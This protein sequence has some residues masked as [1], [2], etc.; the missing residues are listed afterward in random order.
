M[1]MVSPSAV[2]CQQVDE[3]AQGASRSAALEDEMGQRNLWRICWYV[4]NQ[5]KTIS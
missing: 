1:G 5:Q 4:F 3:A 2:S